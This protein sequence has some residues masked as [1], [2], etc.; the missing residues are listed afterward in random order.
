M[1][2]NRIVTAIWALPLVGIIIWFG[3]PYFT[4]FIAVVGLLAAI[5]FYRLTKGIKAQAL[6]VFGIIWTILLIL[7]RNP[8]IY[9]RLSSYIDVEFIMPMIVTL[10]IAVS[11]VLLL[12]RKQ[13]QGA[14]TDWSWT[15]AEILYVGWLLGYLVALRGLD[16]GRSWVF[17]A[18]FV[19]FGSDSAAYFI[20]S[21][22]GK[23]KLAPTI[24]PKKT[25]EGAIG[26]LAG[27]AA[28]SLLFL[29]VKP[30][31]LTSYLNWWQ[32]VIIALAISAVGLMGDLVESLFKRNTGVKDS[33]SIFP[34][35]GGM[36]DRMDSIV[37]A[38]VLVYYIVVLCKF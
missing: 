10:G 23:H 9:S 26:G 31:Q 15:F 13:K 32:L 33:G 7:I 38:V 28:A 18:I 16:N 35:H 21:S 22:F 12:G 8:S 4:T 19:T 11:F 20:G 25:W 36:L 1:L 2:K 30:V 27:A 37:F 3:E 24:S 6:T 29:C 5:E 17:L 34:G 14:F